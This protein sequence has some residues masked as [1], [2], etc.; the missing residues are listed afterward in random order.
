MNSRIDFLSLLLLA[1][2]SS[3][4]ISAQTRFADDATV[5]LDD[6]LQEAI[7]STYIPGLVAIVTDKDAV[8]YSGAFGLRDVAQSHP[9]TADTIFRI[10]SMTKPITSFAIMMLIDEGSLGLEDPVS[11]YLPEL[12][13][14]EVFADFGAT[15]K[16][17]TSRPAS[18]EI[19]IR[20]LLTHT[21]GLGYS[22]TSEILYGLVGSERPSPSTT[23]LPLLHDPG[24]RWTYGESTRV[25]GRVVE[26]LSGLPLEQFLRERIFDPLGM[27]DTGFA[28]PQEKSGRVATAHAKR[29]QELVETANVAAALEV[30]PRGDG[31]L[32]STAADYSKFIRMILNGGIASN[33]VRLLSDDSI[34]LMGQNHIGSLFV[35]TQQISDSARS[36]PFPL[37][38][39]RDRFGLGFQITGTH[40]RD[41]MRS[42]GSLSWAGIMNTE[43]WIDPAKGIGGILLMQYLPFYD[44]TAIDVLE[45]FERRVYQTLQE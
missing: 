3:T 34:D 26:I 7:E 22:F 2:L 16:S 4:Q 33:G 13:D 39:G 25:L 6:Y 32:F 29:G 1:V 19:T 44:E 37:G 14:K 38:A 9:M 43:F 45:G 30:T 40:D 21:S 42:P 18:S 11:D 10:A 17:Y 15:E 12:G 8:T 23:T 20:H 35:E 31:G 27:V 36:E 41:D 24:T 28:V 5:N